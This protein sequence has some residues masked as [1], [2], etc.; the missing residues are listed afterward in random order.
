MQILFLVALV[1]I[2]IFLLK[3]IS[4]KNTVPVVTELPEAYKILLQ[5]HVAFYRALDAEEKKRFQNK[6]AA[7]LSSI[8][9]EGIKTTVEDIDRVFIAASAV[10]PIFAFP[11][12]HYHNLTNV[13]LYPGHFNQEFDMQV[14]EKPVLGM[15]GTGSMNDK[16]ILSKPALHEGFKNETDKHNTAIHE[17]VHLLD[18]MDGDIDGVPGILLEKQ[19]TIP[20]IN[21]MH[22][23]ITNILANRSDINPYGASSKTEFFAVVS[24]YFFERPALFKERHPELFKLMEEIFD[25]YP[26]TKATDLPNKIGRND[27]CPC[28]S[29][30]KYKNCHGRKNSG[31]P[32]QL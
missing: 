7:F 29:G 23:G 22:Q 20:W 32:D 19:Y 26:E 2:A 17:F 12:W 11:A 9:I 15:V 3:G 10:I 24:E 27:P 16:M 18:K 5:Q 14:N 8:T 25:Q 4:K 30:E 31:F 6:M 21:L 1:A 28:G 13:L